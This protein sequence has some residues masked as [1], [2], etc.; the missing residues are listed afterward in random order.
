MEKEI[1]SNTSSIIF[2]CKL[3]IL[4]LAKNIFHRILIPKEVIEELFN[5]NLPENRIIK[6]ELGKFIIKTETKKIVNFPLGSGE[7]AALSL[8]LEKNIRIFL[9]DDKKARSYARSLNI[10]T[11]G[12]IGIILYNLQQKKINKKYARDL[13]DELIQKDYYMSS[14]LYSKIIRLI[15]D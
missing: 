6:E 13:V 10:K 14:E 9:S 1:V 12:V 15:D 8:C 7:K 3:N 2:I 4:D 5:K 11:I